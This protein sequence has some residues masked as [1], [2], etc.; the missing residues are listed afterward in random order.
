M[1]SH[2]Q[3]VNELTQLRQA[4]IANPN[5]CH[6]V[7]SLC[8]RFNRKRCP[9]GKH[10]QTVSNKRR[11]TTTKANMKLSSIHVLWMVLSFVWAMS[12]GG[13]I[14][15]AQEDIQLNITAKIVGGQQAD[16][17]EYRSYAI[18]VIDQYLCGATLIWE[19][20]LVS[21]AHCEEAFNSQNGAVLIGGTKLDG[22]NAPERIPIKSL[23]VHPDFYEDAHTGTP[24]NDIMLIF[25]ANSSTSPVMEWNSDPAVPADNDTVT[26]IGFGTTGENAGVSDDLLEVEVNV[27]NFFSCNQAYGMDLDRDTMMCA[28]APGKDSCYGDSGGPL[29]Y[30]SGSTSTMVGIVSFGIGCAEPAFPSAYTRVSGFDNW[31][32]KG[33]CRGSANPPPMNMCAPFLQNN[34]CYAKDNCDG[35]F[36]SG[37]RLHITFLGICLEQCTT[38][39]GHFLNLGWICG[40]CN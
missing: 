34:T 5:I 7:T 29:F 3:K 11:A 19:D 14:V 40:G 32:L 10:G 27:V 33:L 31:I 13:L 12:S 16:V 25:L 35:L 8:S 38:L 1:C 26:V 24:Y 6:R 22:S 39:Q 21:A 4:S 36:G 15:V 17:G 18:P 30:R 20:V 23:V 28:N 9:H 2:F 37:S